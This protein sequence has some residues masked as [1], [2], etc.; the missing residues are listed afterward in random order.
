[1]P[2]Q[3]HSNKNKKIYKQTKKFINRQ[4]QAKQQIK[5]INRQKECLSTPPNLND[6]LSSMW[7]EI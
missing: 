3:Q 6:T 7:Q 5:Q 1:M 2:N 4:K